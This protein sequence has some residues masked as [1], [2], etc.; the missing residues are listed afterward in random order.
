M[1]SR[2]TQNLRTT[3]ISHIEASNKESEED[4]EMH[5]DNVLYAAAKNLAAD[6]PSS[7]KGMGIRKN[8]S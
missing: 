1:M 8:S 5:H 6:E 3:S 4:Q 2:A 7:N